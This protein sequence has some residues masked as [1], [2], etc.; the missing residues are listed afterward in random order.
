VAYD[1]LSGLDASFLHLEMPETPMHVGALLVLDGE[2]FMRSDGR[3]RLDDV[4]AHIESRLHLI[5]RFRK[6]VVPVPLDVG[7]PIWV[8]DRDFD[9]ARHVRL[10]SVPAPGSREQLL[11]VFEH[12][13]AHVLDRAHPLWELVFVDALEGDHV[14]LIQRTHH[15]LIDGVSGID[16]ASVLLDFTPDTVTA[17][18][19]V[20]KPEPEPR[21]ARLLI[22]TVTGGAA[23]ASVASRAASS[24][25]QV[26]GRAVAGLA[27]LARRLATVVATTTV[28]PATSLNKPVG[29]TRRFATV[30]VPLDDV[31]EVRTAFGGTVNDVVLAGIGG[32]LAQLLDARGELT[33]DLVLQVFCPVSVRHERDQMTLGNRISA[34]FVPIPVGE[35]DPTRRLRTIQATT[36]ELKEREQAVGA[37]ALLSLSQY[38]APTILSLAA[39]LA[40]RQPFFNLIC[41]N[42]PGPQVPMYFLGARVLEAYPMVPLAK[43][44]TV[45]IAVLSYCGAVHVGV[46]A[47]REH[48]LDLDVLEAGI[49]DAFADLAKLA[50]GRADATT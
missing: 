28:A 19:P 13:Q 35:P 11:A 14:A 21:P 18:P 8:D 6:R 40:H 29:A 48:W 7:H 38:A 22:D 2:A 16:V 37:A 30:R 27:S 10:T 17:E 24:A 50:R 12:V 43:N 3:F 23:A 42:V 32:G 44:L 47:D 20:W 4:R 46:L 25:A 49:A 33:P 41:T 9:I 1:R 5:P 31:K 45:G 15:A 36:A 39:R 26:P 34:M